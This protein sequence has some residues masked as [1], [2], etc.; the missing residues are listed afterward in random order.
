MEKLVE[1]AQMTESALTKKPSEERLSDAEYSILVELVTQMAAAYPHQ[2]LGESLEILLRGYEILAIRYGLCRVKNVLQQ[3][4]VTPGQ[5]FFPHPS[6]LA[7]AL[8]QMVSNEY[9]QFLKEN[10]YVSC[11]TCDEGSVIL[12]RDGTPWDHRSREQRYVAD[13]VCRIKWRELARRFKEAS[14]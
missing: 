8:Q 4:L 2:E 5:K 14:S 3:L 13:C 7:E 9:R 11:G 1:V 12:N 10:P 6:Q